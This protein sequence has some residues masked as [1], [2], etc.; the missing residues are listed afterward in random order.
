MLKAQS[1]MEGQDHRHGHGRQ[2]RAAPRRR[3][4]A[5]G[6]GHHGQA[7]HRDLGQGD[8]TSS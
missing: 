4:R 3:R 7:G 6:R 5:H 2:G 1:V 8:A